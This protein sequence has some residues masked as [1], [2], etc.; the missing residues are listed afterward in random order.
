V[1]I[2]ISMKQNVKFSWHS[3]IY[4]ISGI[5]SFH[6]YTGNVMSLVMTELCILTQPHNYCSLTRNHGGE[7][8]YVHID[9]SCDGWS[10]SS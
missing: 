5:S 10:L 8:G 6:E 4:I 3:V 1:K 9:D 2:D 7:D